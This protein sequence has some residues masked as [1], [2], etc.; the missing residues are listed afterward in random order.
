MWSKH[1]AVS[2]WK[3]PTVSPT[4]ALP[5][6]SLWCLKSLNA[7]CIFLSLMVF[8]LF[9]YCDEYDSKLRGRGG[10]DTHTQKMIK[11][12]KDCAALKCQIHCS[13]DECRCYCCIRQETGK[14]RFLLMVACLHYVHIILRKIYKCCKPCL[15]KQM[16]MMCCI[17][18]LKTMNH[19]L[20]SIFYLLILLKM[21]ATSNPLFSIF[22]KK[23]G[24]Y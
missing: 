12:V 23:G 9:L 1:S 16:Q 18:D 8:A 6:S 17:S 7:V 5:W 14:L 20:K 2:S 11:A 22:V 4:A 15:I 3:L 13:T 24:F 19:S 10:G 21:Y